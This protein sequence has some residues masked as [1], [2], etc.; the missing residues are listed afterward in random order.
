MRV[1]KSFSLVHCSIYKAKVHV[2]DFR[3]KHVNP[4][5][6][7]EAELIIST[8]YT[9]ANTDHT[10]SETASFFLYIF[11]LHHFHTLHEGLDHDLD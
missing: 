8:G 10:Q 7:G 1:K 6:S 5:K 9:V 3:E 4:Q 11:L 2:S